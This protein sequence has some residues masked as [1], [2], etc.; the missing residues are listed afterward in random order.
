MIQHRRVKT[1][2]IECSTDACKV[3]K[4]DKLR[5]TLVKATAND[6]KQQLLYAGNFKIR[7]RKEIES[8][9]VKPM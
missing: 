6:K 2:F 5:C 8:L 4:C 7:L 3:A 9:S 1:E